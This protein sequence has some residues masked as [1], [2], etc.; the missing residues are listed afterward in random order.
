MVEN[1]VYI[2]FGIIGL[3]LVITGAI[4]SIFSREMGM[5][6]TLV[7]SGLAIIWISFHKVYHRSKHEE[8]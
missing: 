8:K 7:G 2:A 4:V 3:I 5:A 1:K 6:W